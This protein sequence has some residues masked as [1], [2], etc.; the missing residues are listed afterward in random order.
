MADTLTG[1]TEITSAS[2]ADIS[3]IVQL[4]LQQNSILI[5]TVTDYSGFAVKGSK[6]VAL[7]RS[8]GF[9]VGDKAENT[10]VDAQTSAYSVDTITFN[11]HKVVQF[12]IEEIADNQAKINLVQDYLLKASKDIA[13]QVDQDIITELKLAS[14]SAPDHQIVF[15]DTTTDVIAKGDVLAARKLL[16]EQYINV[17]ECY[18]GI[19]PEKESELLNISDFIDASKYGSNEPIMNVKSEK[20]MD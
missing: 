4:Y 1:V 12:L 17:Q 8:G 20:F 19:G 16:Q 3:S 11:K 2:L 10:A 13:R 18:M 6:S 15:I 9:T 5:P 7:P 14:A